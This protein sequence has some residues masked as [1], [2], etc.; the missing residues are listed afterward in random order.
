[1]SR[2]DLIIKI[3]SDLKDCLHGLGFATSTVVLAC[4]EQA[5]CRYLPYDSVYS[6]MVRRKELEEMYNKMKSLESDLEDRDRQ[7]Q[8]LKKD[9]A[10]CQGKCKPSGSTAKKKA[11]AKKVVDLDKDQS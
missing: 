1:M 6:G 9:L 8:V 5:V 11:A 3:K 2:D 4:F 10:A 7:I